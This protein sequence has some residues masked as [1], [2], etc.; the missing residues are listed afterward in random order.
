MSNIVIFNPDQMRADSMAHMGNSAAV[1]PNLDAFA[2][3]AV[4]FRHAYCQNP[5]CVPSRCSF[6]TGLYPH[7][8]GNRTMNHMLAKDQSS[9]FSELKDAGYYVWMNSRNDFLPA[10]VPDIFDRHC[11][12]IFYNSKRPVVP[13]H[14]E[15][16]KPKNPSEKGYYSFY[17]GRLVPDEGTDPFTRDDEVMEG[18]L[19]FVSRCRDKQPFCMFVGL[20][21][22]HPPY[23]VEEPYFS[24]VK[25]LNL[26]KR[27]PAPEERE[28]LPLMMQRLLENFCLDDFT[29]EDWDQIRTCYLGM[30]MK[31]DAQFG[32][33]CDALKEAG[34]YDDTDIYFFSD[35]GDFTGDYGIPEKA[36]NV[37][38][39]CLTNVPLLIKPHKGVELDPGISDSLVELVDFYATAMDLAGVTPDHTQFGRSLRPVLADRST[40]I[41][42]AVFSEGGR[43]LSETECCSEIQGQTLDPAIEYYPRLKVQE[44]DGAAHGKATMIRTRRYKYIRHLYEQDEFFDLC[45]D[46]EELQ[47][48]IGDPA[49][50]EQIAELS[51]RMLTWYQETCDIVPYQ[52][53]SRFNLEIVW[54]IQKRNMPPGFTLEDMV[55]AMKKAGFL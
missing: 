15:P 25:A 28:T 48:R 3:E 40:E 38:R 12:E 32:M 24:A 54:N 30:V 14:S 19:D 49:C 29:E 1:T 37:L 50:R 35:H 17:H 23:E 43:L 55:N 46:P 7:V 9:I 34:V 20:G 51:E 26:P 2:K 10:Q 36:Q 5:V 18:A 52:R 44:T 33:L 42:D 13:C 53:D 41:R 11:S 16:G 21:H 27:I 22:P 39:D 47:N 6:L 8:Y 4:S 31:V 45:E